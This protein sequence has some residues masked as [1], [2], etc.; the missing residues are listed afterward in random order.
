MHTI[1]FKFRSILPVVL[2][3]DRENWPFEDFLESGFLMTRLLQP[4]NS[5]DPPHP[6]RVAK[7]IDVISRVVFPLGYSIFL[8]Y[9]FAT[10]KGFS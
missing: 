9:F 8:L 7:S 1:C 5:K 10:Y 6:I 4:R 2:H 3:I